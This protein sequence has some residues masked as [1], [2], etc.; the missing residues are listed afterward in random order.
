MSAKIYVV[1]PVCGY[2]G[3]SGPV[4]V[5]STMEK[6]IAQ[7]AALKAKPKRFGYQDN[8]DVTELEL[9]EAAPW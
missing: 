8:W 2:D 4:A 1:V 3:C 9:D 5:F 6:A 7:I